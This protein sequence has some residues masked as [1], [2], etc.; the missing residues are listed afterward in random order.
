VVPGLLP[1]ETIERKRALGDRAVF[2]HG[3]G[4]RWVVDKFDTP[5]SMSEGDERPGRPWAAWTADAID[6][7]DRDPLAS[8]AGRDT[9]AWPLVSK[10][11]CGSRDR[12]A[13]IPTTR[14]R[15]RAPIC[16]LIVRVKDGQSQRLRGFPLARAE[17]Q[18]RWQRDGRPARPLRPPN[19]SEPMKRCTKCR[20]EKPPRLQARPVSERRPLSAMQG[21]RAAPAAGER[22]I[23]GRLSPVVARGQCGEEARDGSPD[24]ERKRQD[25][26]H[27]ERRRARDRLYRARKRARLSD[28]APEANDG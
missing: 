26:A 25:P 9:A 19:S 23:H 10:H 16:E 6:R 15:A 13:A 14:R 20:E 2:V 22:G 3:N 4:D 18:V 7:R 5:G 1:V 11:Q 21:V 24:R 12:E 17:K 27:W 28:T 8:F